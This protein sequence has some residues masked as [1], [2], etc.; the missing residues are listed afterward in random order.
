MPTSP[1]SPPNSV[2]TGSPVRLQGWPVRPGLH[3]ACWWLNL[4]PVRSRGCAVYPTRIASSPSRPARRRSFPAQLRDVRADPGSTANHST[5][6]WCPMR[7]GTFLTSN[8]EAQRVCSDFVN[9]NFFATLRVPA[10][11]ARCNGG[12]SAISGNAWRWRIAPLAC[13][14]LL[15]VQSLGRDGSFSEVL[16]VSATSATKRPL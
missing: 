10:L 14:R 9:G 12:D 6:R 3:R 15:S 1:S 11:P 2:T 5:A 13:G 4:L 16:S 8:G 7:V